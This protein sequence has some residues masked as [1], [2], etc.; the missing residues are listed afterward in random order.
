M[1]SYSLRFSGVDFNPTLSQIV[2]SNQ[3]AIGFDYNAISGAILGFIQLFGDRLFATSR[4]WRADIFDWITAA[5]AAIFL[6][7][8]IFDASLVFMVA[9]RAFNPNHSIPIHA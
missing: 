5:K 7:N 1:T 4:L 9:H 8:T 6:D 2:I 3:I